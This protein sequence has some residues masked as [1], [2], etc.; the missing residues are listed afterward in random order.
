MDNMRY[1]HFFISFIGTL[2][3]VAPMALTNKELLPGHFY[4]E[5]I[6]PLIL[7]GP[8]RVAKFEC[9]RVLGDQRIIEDKQEL[10]PGCPPD[11]Q[12]FL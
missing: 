4:V 2:A 1:F 8:V 10:R 7:D 9:P 6:L 12:I 11:Y 3:E 5:L